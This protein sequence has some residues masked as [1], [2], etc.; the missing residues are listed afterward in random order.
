[1]KPRGRH[2]AQRR[3][4]LSAALAVAILLIL[5]A[6]AATASDLPKWASASVAASREAT[7]AAL[8]V[9]PDAET[10]QILWSEEME[11]DRENCRSI[12]LREVYQVRQGSGGDIGQ[13]A[14]SESDDTRLQSIRIW[15]KDASGRVEE[16]HKPAVSQEGGELYSDDKKYVVGA[17]GIGAGATVARE[18]V[19]R[20]ARRDVWVDDLPAHQDF[21]VL[22]WEYRLRLPA[23]WQAQAFWSDYDSATLTPAPPPALDEECRVWT[24][25]R[26]GVATEEEPFAP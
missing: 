22:R 14:F 4:R 18:V 7:D 11:V 2:A 16:F 26:I 8:Q 12:V 17:T 24:R 1:M 19:Y 21:P 3:R 13:I 10:V 5:P 25:E 6:R 15:R 23:G 20:S 9:F